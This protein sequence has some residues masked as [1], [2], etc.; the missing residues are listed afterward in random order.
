MPPLFGSKENA[1]ITLWLRGWLDI[2]SL[3]ARHI[4]NNV[5]FD[6]RGTAKKGLL[7]LPC[8]CIC[9]Q[10]IWV[11]GDGLL[12][13]HWYLRKESFVTSTSYIWG[14]GISLKENKKWWIYRNFC[15]SCRGFWNFCYYWLDGERKSKVL[16]CVCVWAGVKNFSTQ[17]KKNYSITLFYTLQCFSCILWS[18]RNLLKWLT[19]S[20]AK[21]LF[22]MC[23]LQKS[24]YLRW[25]RNTN[26]IEFPWNCMISWILGSVYFI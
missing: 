23:F 17:Y 6:E 11:K 2:T 16:L 3:H 26:A 4:F 21:S 9:H 5:P 20:N 8:C 25:H 14:S 7:Q 12:A 10:S 19:I 1:N 13:V 15:H 24:P 18:I 22:I